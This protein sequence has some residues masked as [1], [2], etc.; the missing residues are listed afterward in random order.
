MEYYLKYSW[1]CTRATEV[2]HKT[3]ARALPAMQGTNMVV[4][5]GEECDVDDDDGVVVV[6]V[7]GGCP[8]TSSD[9]LLAWAAGALDC[10][11]RSEGTW[12]RW[13]DHIAVVSMAGRIEVG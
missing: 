8:H 11:S 12:R 1:A 3:A 7:V 2:G 4:V 10:Q 13:R 5:H 6:E 9:A